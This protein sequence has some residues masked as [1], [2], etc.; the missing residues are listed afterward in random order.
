[1]N[2]NWAIN[3]SSLLDIKSN[4]SK[5]CTDRQKR[6]PE[7]ETLVSLVTTVISCLAGFLQNKLQCRSVWEAKG[8]SICGISS[9]SS[10]EGHADKT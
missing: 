4:E 1:M 8:S 9:I 6:D 7:N 2:Q 3:N 5:S 10:P